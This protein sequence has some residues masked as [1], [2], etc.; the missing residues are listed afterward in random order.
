MSGNAFAKTST[1]LPMPVGPS[2]PLYVTP[3]DISVNVP[4]GVKQAV[5]PLTSTFSAS[6]YA[7]RM[8]CSLFMGFSFRF[9][10]SNR[11]VSVRVDARVGSSARGTCAARLAG[12]LDQHRGAAADHDCRSIRGP[13][14]D[15]RHHGGVRDAQPAGMANAQSGIHHGPRVGSHPGR[16]DGVPEAG[17][18]GPSEV[19]DVLL[20]RRL[21]TRK[22]LRVANGIERLLTTELAR[23]FDRT[24]YCVKVVLRSEV[25][26][27]DDRG[28]APV[29]A[30]ETHATPTRRLDEGRRD[31]E[32]FAWRCPEAR[33]CLGGRD[34]ELLQYQAEID[35]MARE[36]AW[37]KDLGFDRVAVRGA[38]G[39]LAL[40]LV[41]DARDEDVI[42]EVLPDAAQIRHRGNPEPSELLGD[43]DA[44]QHEKLRRVDGPR[45]KNNFARS[46]DGPH[47]G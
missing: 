11:L 12:A 16:T 9:E 38:V 45:R 23:C 46:T 37:K 39:H 43:S 1:V 7:L 31:R 24:D 44:G 18:A 22:D 15:G 34:R 36:A 25:V 4:S 20:A 41:D 2:G 27:L 32:A 35:G 33:R 8:I 42:L 13:R 30:R 6:S 28:M 3:I 40:V 14:G 26:A 29:G 19:Y 10:L 47:A 5:K 17:G 21:R